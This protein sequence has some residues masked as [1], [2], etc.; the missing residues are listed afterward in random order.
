LRDLHREKIWDPVTRLW[1]WLFATV[2]VAGWSFGKFMS[3]STIQW[4]FYCGYAILGLLA[5]RYLWGFIGPAPVR[6]RSLIR[7][8]TQTFTYLKTITSRDPSG[9][10]G[11]NPLGSLAVIA[12]ILLITAQASSGL[13]IVSDDYFESGPLSYLVSDA[14]SNRLTWW[15]HLLSKFI[16]VIV[17]L[18]V[19]AIFYYL[20]WK[21]EN[22]ISAMITGWKWVKS[23]PDSEH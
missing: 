7:T 2:V 21:K 5:F 20:L 10:R 18:H 9:A 4:H 12:M 11:H 13:F 22:L 6:Y 19:A 17:G 23:A 16:L 8:P 3:F 15:H 1:H 14:A